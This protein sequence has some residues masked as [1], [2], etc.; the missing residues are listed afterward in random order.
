MN[1][2][3][4]STHIGTLFL[5]RNLNIRKFTT[6]V[7]KHIPV[8]DSDIGRPVR[9]LSN[10]SYDFLTEDAKTVMQNMTTLEVCNFACNMSSSRLFSFQRE[11]CGSD[12][13]W[14]LMRTL[15]YHTDHNH[16]GGVVC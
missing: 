2:L 4:A 13:E 16:I 9:H 8:M 3:L 5:D 6:A 7:S 1:N 15:P 14:Y 11:V 12:N 10:N